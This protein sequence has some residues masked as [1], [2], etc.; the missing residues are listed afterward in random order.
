MRII[1]FSRDGAQARAVADGIVQ[2]AFH[3]VAYFGGTFEV[4]IQ[5]GA[6]QYAVI[7]GHSC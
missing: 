4:L 6:M 3:N 7:Q 1:E 2:E 5:Q